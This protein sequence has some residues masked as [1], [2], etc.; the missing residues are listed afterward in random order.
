MTIIWIVIALLI[1]ALII[2]LSFV[3]VGGS[4]TSFAAVLNGAQETP[5]NLSLGSGRFEGVLSSDQNSF[6]YTLRAQNLTSPLNMPLG[7]AS[8]HFHLGA[9]GQAGPILKNI[10]L[11]QT[12][13]GVYETPLGATWST[14]DSSQPLTG[15]DVQNLLR[16][17]VYVNV[18]SLNY[19]N[20]EIRGQVQK[21]IE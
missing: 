4:T 16:N 17:Q 21:F 9:P 13:P 6:S 7:G 3:F 15:E 1:V 14:S 2:V 19:P 11:N 12:S 5:P 8:A 10:V 18:H 20:G